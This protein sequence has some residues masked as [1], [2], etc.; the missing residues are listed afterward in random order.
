MIRRYHLCSL[1]RLLYP[2]L[3]RTKISLYF[4]T[5]YKITTRKY[6]KEI[7]ACA[8]CMHRLF[9]TFICHRFQVLNR[10]NHQLNSFSLHSWT[11]TYLVACQSASN[12]SEYFIFF[13][14]KNT[15]TRRTRERERGKHTKLNASAFSKRKFCSVAQFI[16]LFGFINVLYFF[17]LTLYPLCFSFHLCF[18]DDGS[19][20]P[21]MLFSHYI[22]FHFHLAEILAIFWHH[23]SRTTLFWA[24]TNEKKNNNT[25]CLQDLNFDVQDILKFREYLCDWVNLAT[26]MWM[27]NTQF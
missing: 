23:A 27:A 15:K 22:P 21:L 24:E 19:L 5:R 11:T 2:H 9:Q 18:C 25:N 3:R 26:L 8:V 4:R 12:P 6:L 20:L 13:I 17:L 7:S 1:W 14:Y 16:W 10:F